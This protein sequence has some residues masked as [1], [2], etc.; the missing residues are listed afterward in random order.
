MTGDKILPIDQMAIVF[1]LIHVVS[2]YNFFI[3]KLG[4]DRYVDT[5]SD[6]SEAGDNEVSIP[7]NLAESTNNLTTIRKSESV[8]FEIPLNYWKDRDE[9]IST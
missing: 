7:Q 2:N 1:P 4:P 6:D 9:L 3:D 8:K 5:D